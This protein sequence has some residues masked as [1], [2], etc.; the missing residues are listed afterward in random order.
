MTAKNKDVR[1]IGLANDVTVLMSTYNGEKYIDEQLESILNQDFLGSITI[2]IRDDGS[3][4][5]A[6]EKIK[7]I[8]CKQNRKI[9][10]EQGSN[11]GPQKSFL[12]LIKEAVPA[13]FYFFADQDDVWYLDKIRIA[14]QSMEAVHDGAVCYCSNYSL[15]NSEAGTEKKCVIPERPIF[16]PLRIIFYNQ[17]PGCT[18]GFNQALMQALQ[19]LNLENVMMHDSMALSLCAACGEIL[20]DPEPRILHRIHGDNVVG[21]GHK[22]I[23]PHK[24]IADKLKL[25]IYKD[26]FD[27]SEMARQFL[28][29]ADIKEEWKDDL[30]LLREYKSTFQKTLQ[31]LKHPDSHGV[32][33][34]RTTLSIRC[35]ILFHIF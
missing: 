6:V 20:Y 17:I 27:L 11:V 21:E 8:T 2:Q 4:D 33:M 18:M 31:L 22:K 7:H 32:F 35:K 30:H 5:R 13:K 3:N 28:Q 24:W 26:T 34:D 16:K 12:K 23:I 15:F 19:K 14:V 9:V 25:L 29:I 1:V 10:V